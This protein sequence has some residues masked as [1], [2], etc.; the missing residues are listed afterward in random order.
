MTVL[1]PILGLLL[2]LVALCLLGNGGYLG[3]LLLLGLLAVPTTSVGGFPSVRRRAALAAKG[4][5][6][7]PTCR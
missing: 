4:E 3:A 7:R 5:T 2:T 1:P 6:S